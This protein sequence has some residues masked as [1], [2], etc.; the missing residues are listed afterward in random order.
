MC[1]GIRRKADTDSFLPKICMIWKRMTIPFFI[2]I[3]SQNLSTT[4]TFFSVT[5]F[6]YNFQIC[7]IL[8]PKYFLVRMSFDT[9]DKILRCPLRTNPHFGGIALKA[10]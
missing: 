7:K 1:N 3:Q 4:R 9:F 5:F 6:M 8:S 10:S 2:Y